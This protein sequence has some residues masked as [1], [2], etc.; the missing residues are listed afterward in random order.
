MGT[1]GGP[2]LSRTPQNGQVGRVLTISIHAD[3]RPM[4]CI[5]FHPVVVIGLG[6]DLLFNF[7]VGH[8]DVYKIHTDKKHK[9]NYAVAAGA[10]EGLKT[11]VCTYLY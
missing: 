10:A 11:W 5:S 9:K 7:I 4:L 8:C 2:N 3:F 6:N 1:Q